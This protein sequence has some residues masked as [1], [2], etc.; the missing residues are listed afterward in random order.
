[1][2]PNGMGNYIIQDGPMNCLT[3]GFVQDHLTYWSRL[4][5]W[6]DYAFAVYR[7]MMLMRFDRLR[8]ISLRN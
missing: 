3:A 8:C 2:Q 5:Y 6:D 7:K 1:M 4:T